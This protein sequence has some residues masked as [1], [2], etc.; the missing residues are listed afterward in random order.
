MKHP[1]SAAAI[2]IILCALWAAPVSAADPRV[3]TQSSHLQWQRTQCGPGNI[4]T[5]W[6]NDVNPANVQPEYPR[7]SDGKL[8]YCDDSRSICALNAVGL[9]VP[10]KFELDGFVLCVTLQTSDAAQC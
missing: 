7:Y 1:L 4:P 6:A 9:V 5:Q 3:S 10:L 8:I 2:A